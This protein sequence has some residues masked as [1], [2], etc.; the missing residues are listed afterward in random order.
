MLRGRWGGGT[1]FGL[2][3]RLLSDWALLAKVKGTERLCYSR[4]YHRGRGEGRWW[5]GR[6][7]GVVGSG[8]L[9]RHRPPLPRTST[10]R[11]GTIY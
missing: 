9:V 5:R 6:Q 11:L 2:G 4:R 8:V 3:P 7:R 1:A 10:T